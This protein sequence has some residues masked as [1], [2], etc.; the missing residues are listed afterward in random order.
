MSELSPEA[1]ASDMEE[2]MTIMPDMN[3]N[4][5]VAALAGMLGQSKLP[6]QTGLENRTASYEDAGNAVPYNEGQ[7]PIGKKEIQ[8]AMQTL[9]DYKDGK[10]NLESRIV[11]E[12]RWWK[13]R[14][15]DVI[16]G[17]KSAEMTGEEERPE[18]TSAWMDAGALPDAVRRAWRTDA[19]CVLKLQGLY[20]N[21]AIAGI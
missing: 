1:E 16:R 19:V 14:H 3:N 4:P 6:Q 2:V 18:P 20:P 7:Q 13:L 10:A 9:K 8:Q 11:E 15:W 17:K 12:E 5:I 21:D